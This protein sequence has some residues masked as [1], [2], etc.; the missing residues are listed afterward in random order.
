MARRWEGVC[1]SNSD[2]S[3]LGRPWYVMGAGARS[4][5][6]FVQ[7]LGT[8][9]EVSTSDRTVVGNQVHVVVVLANESESVLRVLSASLWASGLRDRL[10]A[11]SQDRIDEP[12]TNC[13]LVFTSS[14]CC[15]CPCLRPIDE[16]VIPHGMPELKQQ[17]SELQNAIQVGMRVEQGSRCIQY[18]KDSVHRIR[19]TNRGSHIGKPRH[20]DQRTGW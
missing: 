8:D 6:S 7:R 16:P 1:W 9:D 2:K 4:A 12:E 3:E 17:E 11:V 10:S 5:D 20:D 15:R 18:K 13:G 14:D 19:R